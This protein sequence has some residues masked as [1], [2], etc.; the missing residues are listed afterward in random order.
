MKPIDRLLC[1]LATTKISFVFTVC[2]G[3]LQFCANKPETFLA[4]CRLVEGV[5]DG[6]DLNLGCPQMVAKKGRYGAYLQV[7]GEFFFS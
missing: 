2:S 4:A 6:V 3:L 5:C 1:R 7:S